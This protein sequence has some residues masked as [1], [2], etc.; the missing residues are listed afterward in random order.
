MQQLTLSGSGEEEAS[1]QRVGSAVQQ[2]QPALPAL[3]SDPSA[4]TASVL[5]FGYIR[6]T[7]IKSVS[8][9][10]VTALMFLYYIRIISSLEM[11]HI[12]FQ[13]LTE[14]FLQVR[15]RVV[16]MIKREAAKK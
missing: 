9:P 1:P 8:D 16:F 13:L 7:F 6:L 5:I 10:F 4:V 14:G 15:P 3:H 12:C 2:C 11:K